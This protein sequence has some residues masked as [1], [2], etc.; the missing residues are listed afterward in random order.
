MRATGDVIVGS[1]IMLAAA[2]AIGLFNGA[3][4]GY[5]GMIPFVVTLAMMSI[6]AGSAVWLTNSISISHLPAEFI[7]FLMAGWRAC[8]LASVIDV[9]NEASEAPVSGC[10]SRNLRFHVY[11]SAW[12]RSLLRLPDGM[13]CAEVSACP[14][15]TTFHQGD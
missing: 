13:E 4:V 7:S 11:E 2:T 9:R 12:P 8:K 10:A 14:A 1:L 3:A 15:H 6:T 5:L